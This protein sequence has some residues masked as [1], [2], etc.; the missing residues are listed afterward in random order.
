MEMLAAIAVFGILVVILSA[1]L[2]QLNRLWALTEGENQRQHGGRDMLNYLAR[3]IQKAM[4]PL[5]PTS[6]ASLQ[7]V[8]NPTLT[9]SPTDYSYRDNIFFQAPVATDSSYG[10]VAE[11][12]Y[13]VQW[14]SGVAQLC[15]FFVNP[16]YSA[17]S[18]FKIYT[19]P[20]AWLTSGTGN[21]VATVAPATKASNY[22]GLLAENVIGLWINAYDNTGT[23]LYA[24]TRTFD[25]RTAAN[26]PAMID[27]SILV[28]D[29]STA[30]RLSG[31]A[32][33]VATVQG[34]VTSTSYND[35][36]QC[37]PQLPS[38]LLPGASCFATRV[39][40]VNSR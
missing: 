21:M 37:L 7:F 20:A 19:N 38:V 39:Q 4:L 13:F 29:P 5:D 31:N 2:G 8:I 28:L 26:L 33:L 3:D 36:A 34:T 11:V 25:S 27:I 30:K 17:S 10:E 24:S 18:N 14:N 22:Q 32:A 35:A 9:G 23:S 12:G 40:L 1:I 16:T 6:N 15:R